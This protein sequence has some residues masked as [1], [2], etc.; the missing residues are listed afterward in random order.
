MN[1]PSEMMSSYLNSSPNV[2]GEFLRY[3]TFKKNNGLG[4]Y[5]NIEVEEENWVFVEPISFSYKF[6][7]SSFIGEGCTETIERDNP[8][9]FYNEAL[10]IFCCFYFD[11]DCV[12]MFTIPESN[13]IKFLANYDCKKT[14]NWKWLN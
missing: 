10:N 7:I 11:G 6:V 12:L 14:T 8:K 13:G 5:A 3:S 2:L 9:V 4:G 1:F